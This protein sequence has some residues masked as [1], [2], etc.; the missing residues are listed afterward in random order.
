MLSKKCY[1]QKLEALGV[2]TAMSKN[3]N[4]Q[5]TE[6]VC[7]KSFFGR[8]THKPKKHYVIL[9]EKHLPL[10]TLGLLTCGIPNHD[11]NYT[12]TSQGTNKPARVTGWAHKRQ[13]VNVM[14][15]S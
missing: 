11:D 2:T 10:E 12:Y 4:M 6:S 3:I 1:L 9:H 14:G 7:Q 13:N 15:Y 8:T 5:V